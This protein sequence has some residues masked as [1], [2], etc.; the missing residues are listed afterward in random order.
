[1]GIDPMQVAAE[2]SSGTGQ[3]YR[4]VPATDPMTISI[5][6]VEDQGRFNIIGGQVTLWGTIRAVH[7]ETM[8]DVQDRIIRTAEH[9]ANAYGAEAKTQFLQRVPTVD[10]NP[11]WLCAGL[12]TIRRVVG[13]SNVVELL[14]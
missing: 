2:I 5:G 9:I 8:D 7:Q 13:E 3:I 11:A 12:P 6:H 4:Q 14:E 1:M 10:N